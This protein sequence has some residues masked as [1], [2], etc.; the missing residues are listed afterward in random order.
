[1]IKKEVTVKAN[2]GI[3]A[4]PAAKIVEIA[5]QFDGKVT[6]CHGCNKAD[7]CSILQVLLLSAEN[8]ASVEVTVDG[9]DEE[10]TIDR[11]IDVFENGGGI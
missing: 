6:L 2:N 4:R 10:V 8:G 9:T 1:M 3:H 11:I 5:Q 7:G